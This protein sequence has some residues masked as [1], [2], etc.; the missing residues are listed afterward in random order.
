MLESPKFFVGNLF[1][2]IAM[3]AAATKVRVLNQWRNFCQIPWLS[4]G[5]VLESLVLLLVV[6]SSLRFF[7]FSLTTQWLNRLATSPA[8]PNRGSQVVLLGVQLA[9]RWIRV[10]ASE[11]IY[12][13][14]CLSQ[15]LTFRSILECHG[16]EANLHIGVRKSKGELDAHAW[17][18]CAGIVL[19]ERSDVWQRFVA[20]SS[21]SDLRS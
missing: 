15:C 20:L 14:T 16:I 8:R 18:E 7:G 10:L 9:T 13:S 1:L 21:A 4:R 11:G 3:A 12:R 17:I 19:N 2:L 6:N 5:I